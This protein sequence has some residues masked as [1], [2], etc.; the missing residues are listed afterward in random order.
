MYVDGHLKGEFGERVKMSA[1]ETIQF[2]ATSVIDDISKC[3]SMEPKIAQDLVFILGSTANELGASEYYDMFEKTGLNIPHVNFDKNKNLYQIL[4]Q[5]IEKELVASC[6]AVARG[7]IGVHLSLMTMAGGFGLDINLSDIV[8]NTSCGKLFDETLLF[9]ESAGRFLVTISQENRLKF[10]KMFS[11]METAC[12]G[13]VTSKHDHLKIIA[14]NKKTINKKTIIDL[15][16]QNMET[17]FNKTFGD[18]I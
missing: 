16:I 1:L 3:I 14:Q 6:H 9:S 17:A 4:Q 15:S 18:M 10:E 7:G 12:I 11:S 5:A 2:S 8:Q 13:M